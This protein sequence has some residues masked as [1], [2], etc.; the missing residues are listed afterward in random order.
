MRADVLRCVRGC[1]ALTVSALAFHP[2]NADADIYACAGDSIRIFASSALGDDPP[3]RVISGSAT[4]LSECYGVALDVLHGEIWV[5]HGAVS[6]FRSTANGNVAPLRRIDTT[7]GFAGSVAVDVAAGEVIVSTTGGLLLTFPRTASGNAT[8]SRTLQIGQSVAVASAIFVDRIHEEILVT[9]YPAG[10]EFFA[11]ARLQTGPAAPLRPPIAMPMSALRAL[12]VDRDTDVVYVSGSSGIMAVQRTGGPFS[13]MIPSS[14]LNAPWGMTLTPDR[15]LL[16]DQSAD[17]SAPDPIHIHS[18]AGQ[19]FI[20][21]IRNGAPP[22]RQLFGITAT[23][24][25]HCAAG[26]TVDDCLFRDGVEGG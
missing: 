17:P 14:G 19:G 4:G 23:A 10:N 24:A 9:P 3:L 5:A 1:I 7:A 8:P 13:Q 20:G 25:R 15:L 11:F 2:G 12:F 26:N 6:V 18:P 21:T 16:A 22:G